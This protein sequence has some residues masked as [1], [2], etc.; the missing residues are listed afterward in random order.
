MKSNYL[1][2]EHEFSESAEVLSRL[3]KENL[4][5]REVR[6][7]SISEINPSLGINVGEI[8]TNYL[9]NLGILNYFLVR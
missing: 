6:Q 3:S 5:Q 9:G 8:Q 4:F 2:K 1:R 7:L